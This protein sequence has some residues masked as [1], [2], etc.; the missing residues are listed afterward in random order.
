MIPSS[1]IAFSTSGIALRKRSVCAGVQ[2]PMTSSTPARLYQL[3]SKI[4]TSPAEGNWE[5]YRWTYICELTRASGAGSAMCLKTRGLVRSVMRLIV[6]PF[7]AESTPSKTTITL[8]PVAL[9]HSCIA[10]SSPWST[11]MWR[12]YSFRFILPP[13]LWLEASPVSARCFPFL[14]GLLIGIPSLR[15]SAKLPQ[16]RRGRKR[17]RVRQDACVVDVAEAAVDRLHSLVPFLCPRDELDEAAARSPLELGALESVR[18]APPPP[19]PPHGRQPVLGHG[20][21]V[22]VLEQSGVA[23]DVAVLECHERAV[24]AGCLVANPFVELERHIPGQRHVVVPLERD[25]PC[26]PQQLLP[27]SRQG[28]DL[29]AGRRGVVLLCPDQA[30]LLELVVDDLLAKALG[31][32]DGVRLVGVDERDQLVAAEA[33]NVVG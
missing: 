2:Y 8:A 29:D 25:R 28:D 16:R 33:A 31:K 10:T 12:S 3:R 26:G 21:P 9:I 13:E 17:A 1:T 23:D 15:L 22:G 18:D 32:R 24:R 6:P 4:T 11:R 14:C 7:P 19:V 27:A 20:G 30:D 5:M